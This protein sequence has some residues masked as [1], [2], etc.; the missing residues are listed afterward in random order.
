MK[1]WQRNKP[2]LFTKNARNHQGHDTSSCARL[3]KPALCLMIGLV[4][5]IIRVTFV[6]VW[7][8]LYKQV[9]LTFSSNLTRLLSGSWFDI[10]VSINV[11]SDAL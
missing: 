9:T 2:D 3:S 1:Q 10:K 7:T 5:W 4:V 11:F 8:P 6:L